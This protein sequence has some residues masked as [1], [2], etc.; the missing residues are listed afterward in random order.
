MGEI[1]DKKARLVTFIKGRGAILPVQVAKELKLDTM[2]SGA[3]LSE[4]VN[5][6]KIKVSEHLRVGGSPVYYVDERKL[7]E[8]MKYLNEQDVKT[9]SYLK[10]RGIV[11]DFK[12]TPLQRVSYRIVKDFAKSIILKRDDNSKEIFWRYYLLDEDKAKEKILEIVNNVK[13]EEVKPKK[14]EEPIK[15]EISIVKKKTE[16]PAKKTAEESIVEKPVKKNVEEIKI[17]LQEPGIEAK[18]EIVMVFFSDNDI[19]VLEEKMIKKGK[20]SNYVVSFDTRVGRV[21]YFVKYRDKKTINEG[22]LSL[23][24]I[25]AGKLPLLLLSKGELNKNAKKL[26]ESDYKGV[27]FRR[28]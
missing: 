2:F 18:E 1:N 8:Y 28:I 19:T 20:E 22:D 11:S 10:E 17:I 5:E 16:E 4:L 12:C 23:A 7:E 27:V 24:F 21:K 6:G 13:K 15:E 9:I 3:I 25:E 26:I 14:I